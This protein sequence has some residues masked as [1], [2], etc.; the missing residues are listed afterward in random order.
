MSELAEYLY[1][2]IICVVVNILLITLAIINIY[3][4]IK[5]ILYIR[6]HETSSMLTGHLTYGIDSHGKPTKHWKY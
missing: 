4:S 2:L 1:I 6:S 5:R 3:Y